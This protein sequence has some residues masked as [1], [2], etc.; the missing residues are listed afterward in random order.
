MCHYI[1]LSVH[2]YHI[3]YPPTHMFIR[4]LLPTCLHS[5]ELEAVCQVPSY[6]LGQREKGGLAESYFQIERS[7]L[8]VF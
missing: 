5:I 1:W 2:I 7:G 6:S 4:V 8:I 3:V